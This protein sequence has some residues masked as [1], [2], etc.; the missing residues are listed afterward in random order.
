MRWAGHV[1]DDK[2]TQTR[3]KHLKGRGLLER[4]DTDER[5]ECN[6]KMDVK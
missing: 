1:T 4:P 2:N 6:I 5:V 3:V